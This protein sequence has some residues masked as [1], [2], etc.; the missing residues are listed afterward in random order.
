MWTGDRDLSALRAL[1]RQADELAG[2][3]STGAAAA[4]AEFVGGDEAGVVE[5]TIDA[6]GAPARVRLARDWHQVVAVS[7]LG[8]AVLTALSAA[9]TQ[10]LAAWAHGVEQG[11]QP[12]AAPGEEQDPA[13]TPAARTDFGG[14]HRVGEPLEIADPTSRQ[15]V[16][17]LRDLMNL[18][19]EVTEGLGEL[20]RTATATATAT[21]TATATA[22]E[23]VTSTNAGRTVRVTATG[24][25]V[26]AIECDERWLR[27]TDHER[28]ADAIQEALTAA[29]RAGVTARQELLRSVPGL[30]RAR[31]LTAS[32]ETL[33]REIGL[34]R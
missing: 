16:H 19:A 32:P 9:V 34:I 21:D 5:V 23:T 14:H 15:A 13:E 22:D 26:T 27:A 24:G 8:P 10:R 28:V 30:D 2:A 4:Q 1:Q 7:G 11:V 29:A 3:L 6:S 20:A 33:F 18:V 25:T 31:R 17:G 12:G